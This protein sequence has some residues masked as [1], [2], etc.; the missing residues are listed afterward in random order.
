MLSPKRIRWRKQHRNF[1]KGKAL[2]GTR[3]SFGDIGLKTMEHGRITNRQ[4][5]AARVAIM[6]HLKR[7]GKVYIRIFPDKPYTSKPAET[8][9]GKGKGTPEG[10]V[11][12]V[13][14]GRVMFE[15]SGVNLN[16]AREAML[17]AAQKL[18]VKAKIEERGS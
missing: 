17:L 5:E 8:R 1:D 6:R 16:R 7:G 10:Y 14:P 18:P 4:I 9:M 11:A 2:R 13:K 3:V 15:V 12:P